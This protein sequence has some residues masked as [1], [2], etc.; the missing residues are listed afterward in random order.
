MQAHQKME[1]LDH[2]IQLF[3]CREYIDTPMY[4]LSSGQLQVILL[5]NMFLDSRELLLLDEPFQFLDPENHA[6]VT[7]YLH[8]F[9]DDSTTLVMITHDERDVAEWTELRKQL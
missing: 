8:Q 2:L 5:M 1:Q 7:R 6:R 9:L 3:G 4:V